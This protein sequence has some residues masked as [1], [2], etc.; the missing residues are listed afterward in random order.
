MEH[1]PVMREEIAQY[2]NLNPGKVVLD[3]TI[4]TGGHAQEI[5][6]K[7]APQGRLIGVDRDAD[8]LSI[9]ENNLKEFSGFYTLIKDDFRHLDRILENLKVQNIDGILFDL[10]ISSFQLDNSKRGFSIREDG[11][12]DMRMDKNSYISAYD[13]VNSL[14]ETEISGILKN[15]GQERWHNRIAHY[16]VEERMR[17]PIATTKQLSDIVMKAVGYRYAA[18]KIHPATRTFQAF[19]IAVNRELE[20]LDMALDKAIRSLSKGGRICVISFHSLE[21]KIVKEKFKNFSRE[22]ILEIITKKPLRSTEQEV[23]E[24]VRARSA[25]LRVAERI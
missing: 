24:N 7:I 25:R 16:L 2:L 4:G 23:S 8:S 1:K 13:L 6:R 15:F 3:C 21:D 12:L 20:A 10:G 19:R 14:S 5:L 11:P 18:Q 9:A 17:N 22:G